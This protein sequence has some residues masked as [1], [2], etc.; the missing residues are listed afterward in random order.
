MALHPSL[1][2]TENTVPAVI[3]WL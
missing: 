1:I 2:H 3:A